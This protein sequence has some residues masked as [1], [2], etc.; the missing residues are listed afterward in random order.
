MS[1]FTLGFTLLV[2][3]VLVWGSASPGT[4]LGGI[5][6]IAVMYATFPSARPAFPAF[7]FHPIRA[8][9]LV[10]Y[11]V[12]Q[13]IISNVMLS[14]ELLRPRP[15]IDQVVVDV[16]MHTSSASILTAVSNLCAMSPGTMVVGVRTEPP[17]L[18]VHVLVFGVQAD[19]EPAVETIRTLERLAIAAFG[20]AG[21]REAYAAVE[22]AGLAPVEVVL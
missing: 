18:R 20:T 16:P 5:V 8:A 9:R 14:I 19:H 7:N 4:I 1:R 22:A 17:T 3:W 15:A 13:L 11:F 10:A 2:A 21:D 12:R 6:V